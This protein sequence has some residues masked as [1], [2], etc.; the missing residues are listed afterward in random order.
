MYWAKEINF[1]GD[2]ENTLNY[3]IRVLGRKGVLLLN[4]IA[5]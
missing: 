1:G 4:F 5:A 3:N 2:S